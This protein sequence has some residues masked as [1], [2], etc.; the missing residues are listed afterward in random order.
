MKFSL[1]VHFCVNIQKCHIN[2]TLK[3][4]EYRRK[5][6]QLS[7]LVFCFVF[8]LISDWKN[9]SQKTLTENQS[10]KSCDKLEDFI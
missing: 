9:I 8:F 7:N 6:K 10:P 5:A 1:L 2:L 4:K 3:T